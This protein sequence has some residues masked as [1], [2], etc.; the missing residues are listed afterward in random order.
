M[1]RT[2]LRAQ[3]FGVFTDI[4]LVGSHVGL[5][6]ALGRVLEVDFETSLSVESTKV[7]NIARAR[8]PTTARTCES[9]DY[10]AFL[11]DRGTWSA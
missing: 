5:R 1:G 9:V 2:G 6:A 4:S 11:H 8:R 7:R 3:T 10:L